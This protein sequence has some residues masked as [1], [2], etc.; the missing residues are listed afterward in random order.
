MKTSSFFALLLFAIGL[1]LLP[2]N[3]IHAEEAGQPVKKLILPGES[4][5]LEGHPAFI[6]WPAEDKRQ[7]PQPW[8]LYAPTLPA[9]PDSHEKWMHQQLVDAG[10]AVAGIDVGE[11]YGSPKAQQAFTALYTELTEQ[12]GFA[13]KPCLL[14]R[15][16]GGLWVSSWAIRNTDKV[17]GIAG[18]YPVF[19]LRTYPGLER[20]APAYGL[21]VSELE[22]TLGKNNPISQ[23]N[24]LAEAKIPVYIIHGDEDRV[25]PLKENSATL[26]AAYQA[27]GAA[28]SLELVVPQGQGHNFWPGFF[29]C[30]SLVDFSIDRA[31]AGAGLKPLQKQGAKSID[32]VVV[33]RDLPYGQAGNKPLL[34]DMYYPTNQAGPVP[35]VM[36]V[37]GG[38]WKNGSKDRCPATWLVEQGYAVASIDY[39]LI[40]EAQW[41]AQIDD[42]R[43]AVRWLR[44]NAKEFQLDANHI[45]VWGGS[46]GGHLAALLGTLDAPPGEEVS[47][48]VQAVCD[49]YGPSDLLTMPPNVVG[50]GRTA[51]DVAKS[52]GARL[53]GGPVRELPDLAKQA[54][55]YYQVSQDDPPFLIMHG[56]Q[57]PGVPLEQSQKLHEQL[58]KTGVPS[59]F[60][61]VAGA[62][63]GGKEFQTT[64]VRQKILAFFN[65]HLLRSAPP[66]Q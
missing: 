4:F 5:L 19:D 13:K 12:R 39:R 58:E 18:I 26:A 30:Q 11:A 17:A 31:R 63:H 52:N 37:H 40:D 54:S 15:S 59:T 51:E 20:A 60:H 42:C 43:T 66:I 34:L 3:R 29:H 45:G 61:I 57:D 41:P 64:E 36:W 27:A 10:I 2:L 14:G 47:S 55:A 48:R 46:A 38:G 22:K 7:D 21:S 50:N 33:Y 24:K 35:V 62:G 56:S 28:E 49:W 9:Y 16:R 32:H 53:L 8:V 6:L 23:V 65:E 1:L 25:V 44:Q